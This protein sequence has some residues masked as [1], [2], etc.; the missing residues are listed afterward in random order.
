M[1][2][3]DANYINKLRSRNNQNLKKNGVVVRGSGVVA[4]APVRRLASGDAPSRDWRGV[5][6]Q[7]GAIEWRGSDAGPKV[8]R[9]CGRPAVACGARHGMHPRI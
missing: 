1:S 8:A 7:W 4:P 6:G 5:R 9:R 2:A 3:S